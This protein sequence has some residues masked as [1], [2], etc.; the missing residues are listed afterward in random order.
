MIS[1]INIKKFKN[2]SLEGHPTGGNPEHWAD[3]TW[4]SRKGWFIFFILSS[5]CLPA[6]KDTLSFQAKC[7]ENKSL[8]TVCH[9]YQAENWDDAK[10]NNFEKLD[11]FKWHG[12]LQSIYE[13]TLWE[14]FHSQVPLPRKGTNKQFKLKPWPHCLKVAL[15]YLLSILPGAGSETPAGCFRNWNLPSKDQHLRALF[16][17]VFTE[18]S[19]DRSER[20][21]ESEQ[22][23]SKP[24]VWFP[25]V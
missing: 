7:A 20:S 13:M 21:F 3:V 25:E 24:G 5:L 18:I 22:I 6:R 1:K 16:S 15:A 9:L 23:N 10:T 8:D 11:P 14:C 4:V 19:K 12:Y 17:L 2:R